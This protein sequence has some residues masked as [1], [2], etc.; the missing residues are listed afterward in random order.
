[1]RSL[2]TLHAMFFVSTCSSAH[3]FKIIKVKNFSQGLN[4]R[5]FKGQ[6]VK[7]CFKRGKKKFILHFFSFLKCRLLLWVRTSKVFE[8]HVC[9]T[10]QIED[11]SKTFPNLITFSKFKGRKEEIYAFE[12][13]VILLSQIVHDY[14]QKKPTSASSYTP[15]FFSPIKTHEEFA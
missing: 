14:T 13:D 6:K 4:C 1:M 8:R 3:N 12:V 11:N 15:S 9:F 7:I 5:E 2:Q 10:A